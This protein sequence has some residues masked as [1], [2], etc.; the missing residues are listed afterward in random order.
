[1]PHLQIALGG[2][3]VTVPDF[4]LTLARHIIALANAGELAKDGT[5]DGDGWMQ[6]ATP[7]RVGELRDEEI[8]GVMGSMK[9]AGLFLIGGILLFSIA[10]CVFSMAFPKY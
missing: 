7:G 10:G 3:R 1:M 8:H 2:M 6:D 9:R 4:Q 5:P